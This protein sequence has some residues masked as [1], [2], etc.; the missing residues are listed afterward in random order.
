MSVLIVHISMKNKR[1]FCK[2]QMIRWIITLPLDELG[3]D[4]H[5]KRTAIVYNQETIN[6][7]P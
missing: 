5:L 1:T 2:R 3:G 6:K 4:G 7:D